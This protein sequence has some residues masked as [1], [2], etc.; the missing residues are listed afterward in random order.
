MDLTCFQIAAYKAGMTNGEFVYIATWPFYHERYGNMSWQYGKNEE[1]DRVSVFFATEGLLN[2]LHGN[3]E[4]FR[5]NYLKF[6]TYIQ[7]GD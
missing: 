1:E 7:I 5:K 6:F 4:I 2:V 3:P